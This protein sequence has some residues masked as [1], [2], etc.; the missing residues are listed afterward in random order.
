MP[1]VGAA[2]CEGAGTTSATTHPTTGYRSSSISTDPD[3]SSKQALYALAG[4]VSM[5]CSYETRDDRGDE[6]VVT[7]D[8]S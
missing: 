8:T 5:K 4:V 6:V 3:I 2:I 7:N 1:V